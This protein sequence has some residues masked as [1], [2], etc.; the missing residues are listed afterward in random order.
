MSR[1]NEA[2][3]L[4]VSPALRLLERRPII[5]DVF[6][7]KSGE[8]IGILSLPRRA[9]GLEPGVKFVRGH[10]RILDSGRIATTRNGTRMTRIER[11]FTDFCWQGQDGSS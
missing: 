6:C 11:I 9:V 2:F 4:M 10:S 8:G 3:F 5:A 7:E 1:R